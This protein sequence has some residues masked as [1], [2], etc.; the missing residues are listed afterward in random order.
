MT[1]PPVLP[2]RSGATRRL[3]KL[4][5]VCALGTLFPL[6]GCYYGWGWGVPAVSF[7]FGYWGGGHWH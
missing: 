4:A 5:W 7:G 1:R 6:S 3:R 2:I